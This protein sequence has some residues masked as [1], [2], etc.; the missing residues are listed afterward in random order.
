M[1]KQ[2][3]EAD[4]DL[5]REAARRNKEELSEEDREKN[6]RWVTVGKKGM[7]KIIKKEWREIVNHS[8]PA[9]TSQ[10]TRPTQLNRKRMAEVDMETNGNNKKQRNQVSQEA[11]TGEEEVLDL[12]QEEEGDQTALN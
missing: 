5:R 12:D 9:I 3:R 1:T 2:Q 7:R 10:G 6:M 11:D 8:H 4:E